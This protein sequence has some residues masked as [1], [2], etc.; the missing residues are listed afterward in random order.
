MKC[1]PTCITQLIILF[2]INKLQ[3]IYYTKTYKKIISWNINNIKNINQIFFNGFSYFCLTNSILNN[4][5]NQFIYCKGHNHVGQLGM[6][7]SH[8]NYNKWQINN[9]FINENKSKIKFISNGF[10]NCHTF[11]Y[12]IN[13][14]L[15]A[16]GHNSQGQLGIKP[17]N[18]ENFTPKMCQFKMNYKEKLIDIQCGIYHSLFL[19]HFGCVYSCGSNKYNQ[20][21]YKT[22]WHE[23]YSVDYSNTI[24]K[25]NKLNDIKQIQCSASTSY[26]LNKNGICY[27][28]GCKFDGALGV[29]IHKINDNK[30]I[31]EIKNLK[32]QFISSGTE[33]CCGISLNDK[34]FFWGDNFYSQCGCKSNDGKKKIFVP[35]HLIFDKKIKSI[36]CGGYHNII[37]TIDRFY[38]SFGKNFNGECLLFV[39]NDKISIPTKISLDKIKNK[40]NFNH[41]IIDIVPGYAKSFI[42]TV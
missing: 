14:K 39:S 24:K 7:E 17:N 40:I 29:L 34:I 11:F 31:N 38:Y 6:S 30:I 18:N 36:K 8:D 23:N 32:F 1:I 4:D 21:G 5:I 12:T 37:K 3:E 35:K 25:I 28:F 13:N 19:T 22:H 41:K 33:H 16:C 10:N 9:F 2:Y 42:I 27:S 26:A 15:F 20:L